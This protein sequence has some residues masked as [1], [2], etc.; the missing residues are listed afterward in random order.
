M[1]LKYMSFTLNDA[2]V[3]KLLKVCKVC[4]NYNVRYSIKYHS[5]LDAK[6]GTKFQRC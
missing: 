2:Q 3:T 1:L 4:L 5:Q 6:Y